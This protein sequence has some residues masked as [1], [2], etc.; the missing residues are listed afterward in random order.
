M[1]T[2]HLIA[3][4]VIAL[5]LIAGAAAQAQGLGG[6]GGHLGGGFNGAGSGGINHLGG[7]SGNSAFNGAAGGSTS[8]LASRAKRDP[9]QDKPTKSGAATTATGSTQV[10]GAAS[11]PAV[12]SAGGLAGSASASK[13]GIATAAAGQGS[14]GAGSVNVNGDGQ[15]NVS[16]SH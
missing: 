2:N 9:T 5:G 8:D 6:L 10:S 3:S 1:K 14:A 11:K 13:N 7:A 12:Q 16:V 15:A 4:S